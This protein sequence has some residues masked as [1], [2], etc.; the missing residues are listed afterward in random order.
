[1]AEHTAPQQ[2]PAPHRV[3]P[4]QQNQAQIASQAMAD[5]AVEAERL[6]L[7]EAGPGHHYIVN[8]QK[9]LADGTPY[10]GKAKDED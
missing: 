8:G 6:Q 2:Q 1:M 9:V 3:E 7:D 4:V 10:K 5:A